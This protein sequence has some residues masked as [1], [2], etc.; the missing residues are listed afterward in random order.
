MPDDT[1]NY[2]SIARPEHDVNLDTIAKD[3]QESAEKQ[4]DIPL[5]DMGALVFYS[6]NIV[7]DLILNS[8]FAIPEMISIIV[9]IFLNFFAVNAYVATY[10]KLLIW[11]VISAV[12][13]ISILA[14]IMNIRSGSPVV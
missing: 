4:M 3:I 5:L 14:F 9:N 6:G 12:Y 13:I 8:L 2:V 10:A 1:L 11:A 7:V